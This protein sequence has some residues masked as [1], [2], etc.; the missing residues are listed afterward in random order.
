MLGTTEARLPSHRRRLRP[1]GIHAQ[2]FLVPISLAL[3]DNQPRGCYGVS[4]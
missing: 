2:P 3:V 4:P 1:R